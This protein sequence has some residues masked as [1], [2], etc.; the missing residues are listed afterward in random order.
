MNTFGALIGLIFGN[1]GNGL[2][3]AEL[4]YI[5][6]AEKFWYFFFAVLL[7]GPALAYFKFQTGI[8]VLMLGFLVIFATIGMRP[9]IAGGVALAGAAG[10]IPAEGTWQHGAALLFKAYVNCVTLALIWGEFYLLILLAFPVLASTMASIVTITA[11]LVVIMLVTIYGL[12]KG[13]IPD[14]NW[15]KPVLAVAICIMLYGA[16]MAVPK[17]TLARLGLPT[18]SSPA[19]EAEELA[20][21]M[22]DGDQAILNARQKELLAG[23]IKIRDCKLTKAEVKMM[24]AKASSIYG[25]A[26]SQGLKRLT[27]KELEE[28]FPAAFDVW[29]KSYGGQYL[30]EGKVA[31]AGPSDGF[32]IGG[33]LIGSHAL[34]F[35]LAALL[36]LGGGT[37]LYF[38]KKK[39]SDVATAV[40]AAAAASKA[41]TTG[42][43]FISRNRGVLAVATVVGGI[44]GYNYGPSAFP[45]SFA[46]STTISHKTAYVASST[47]PKLRDKSF[48]VR[49]GQ[50]ACMNRH[51]N[52]VVDVLDKAK[53]GYDKRL[54]ITTDEG[55]YCLDQTVC[56]EPKVHGDSKAYVTCVGPWKMET[57]ASGTYQAIYGGDELRK[58]TLESTAGERV[59]FDIE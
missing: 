37:G 11:S 4:Q 47:N 41:A 10:G 45:D 50:H 34:Y 12:A 15:H 54:A 30:K 17:T 26:C 16:W 2:R 3:H 31:T 49:V 29:K 6:A 43:G 53:G 48:P 35:L 5:R 7:G 59:V 14:G 28:G 39:K 44:A 20:V 24:D 38:W 58:V 33:I 52:K 19:T 22:L 9:K 18:A 21:E 40:P 51:N 56:N 46:E 13:K 27:L 57:I 1:A 42:P 36:G 55:I 8:W 23:A 25:N 32:V